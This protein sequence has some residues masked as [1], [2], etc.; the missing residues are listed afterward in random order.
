M[1]VL[2]IMNTYT[3]KPCEWNVPSIYLACVICLYVTAVITL[4]SCQNFEYHPYAADYYGKENI[5]A[6]N[7]AR[8]EEMCKGKDT[9]CFAF[10]TDT[11]GAYD[12]FR[13]VIKQLDRRGDVMFIIHGGD[14]SDF[15]LTKEFLWSRDIMESQHRP[16]LCLIGNHDCL[17]NGEHVFER[18]YGSPNY[19]L[20]AGFLHLVGL[21]T[22]ALEYDYSHPVPDFQFLESDTKATKSMQDS[23]TNTIVMMHAPPHDEQFNDNVARYFQYMV[24]Q[25][26][27]LRETDENYPAVYNDTVKAGTRTKGF[28]LNGH[29]HRT[30]VKHIF[31]DGVLYYGLTNMSDREIRVFTITRQGYEC[32]TIKY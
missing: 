14:Q 27:G 4:T 32:E 21:N 23:I 24:T 26:P 7:I 11:Q 6:D 25:Y 17:G 28:C 10:I 15:G 16:Y 9:I 18:M 3:N 8:I 1:S 30:D 31:N 2:R 5:H 13:D 22:V 19:S 12:E 29:T 20:N